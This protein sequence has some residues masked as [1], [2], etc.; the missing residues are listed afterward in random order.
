MREIPLKELKRMVSVETLLSY[1]DC[2]IPFTVHTGASN[3]QLGYFI[4]Q[5]NKATDL[6]PSRLS[7]PQRD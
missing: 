4:S 3:K 7:R 5:N 1:P 2:K 6:F